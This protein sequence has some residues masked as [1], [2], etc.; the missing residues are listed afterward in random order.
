VLPESLGNLTQLFQIWISS[1]LDSFP[2]CIREWKRLELLWLPECKIDSIPDWLV[3]L[4]N[5]SYIRLERN[6]LADLPTS[7]AQLEHLTNLNIT[8]NP[9]NPEFAK[10]YLRAKAEAQITLNEAKLISQCLLINMG[11]SYARCLIILIHSDT[12]L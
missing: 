5:L 12:R 3:E 1:P 7:L 11:K 6:N 10:A 8:E 4:T 2:K 9:L